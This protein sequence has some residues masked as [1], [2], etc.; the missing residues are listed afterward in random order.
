MLSHLNG[1]TLTSIHE[2]WKNH[3]FDYMTFVG[4]AMSLLF[5]M[6]SSFVITFLPRSKEMVYVSFNFMA[7]VTVHSDFGA[8]ENTTSVTVPIVS[9]FICHEA[10]GPNIVILVF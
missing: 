8:Q 3:S 5:N 6:L 2:Y 9:P 4:K 7:A 1:P 10:M